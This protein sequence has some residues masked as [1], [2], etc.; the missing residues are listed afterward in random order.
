MRHNLSQLN[1][2]IGILCYVLLYAGCNTTTKSEPEVEPIKRTPC[3]VLRVFDGDTFACDLNKNRKVE[4]PTEYIR[5]LG[6]DT[7]ET[8]NSKRYAGTSKA[9]IAEPFA[10]EA[11]A[12]LKQT[13]THQTVYLEFD[14]QQYDRYGRT[15]AFVYLSNTALKSVNAAILEQ[16]LATTLF[17]APNKKYTE[18]LRQATTLARHHKRGLW[19]PKP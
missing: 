3:K 9:G 8:E 5:L 12:F 16:G 13:L 17:I 6:I 18:E 7:P 1:L 11:S 4:K 14:R 19:Q 10:N 15:L 2:I